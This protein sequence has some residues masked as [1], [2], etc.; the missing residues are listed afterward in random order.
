[1]TK[2]GPDGLSHAEREE[3]RLQRIYDIADRKME[4]LM[5]RDIDGTPIPCTHY[6]ECP[7]ETCKDTVE[8]RKA[9]E[10]QYHKTLATIETET[11]PA[12]KESLP[13]NGPSTLKSRVAAASLSLP[14]QSGPVFKTASKPNI[15]NAKP[16]LTTSLIARPKTRPA[17]TNPSPMRHNAAVAASKT[18]MGYSKGRATSATLRKTVL[19]KKEVKTSSNEIPDTSLAPAE[20]IRRYGVPQ[21]GSEMWIRCRAVGC[22]DEDVGPNLE[23]IFAGDHPHGLDALLRKEAEQDFQLTF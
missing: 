14:K 9:A 17:P 4:A 3:Q 19:P 11:A 7:T 6:P 13:S 16:R 8:A 10:E 22:F 5:Q 15:A 21:V 2:E 20:Y 1:M 18:T 23:E 12:T